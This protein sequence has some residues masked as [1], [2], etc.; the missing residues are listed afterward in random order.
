LA[1]LHAGQIVDVNPDVQPEDHSKLNEC[2]EKL[3]RY[4]RRAYSR[5]K[6]ALRLLIG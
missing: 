1:Q 4:E 3:E 2:L 5:R 6:R